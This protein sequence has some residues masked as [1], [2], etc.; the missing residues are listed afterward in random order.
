MQTYSDFLLQ[1]RKIS[2]RN[3][4]EIDKL[5]V[6]VVDDFGF[7][8]LLREKNGGPAGERLTIDFVL[9]YELENSL[10]KLL[11]APVVS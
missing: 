7:G 2:L 4:I 11:V 10:G 6:C 8:R 3:L 9:W 5:P 1:R